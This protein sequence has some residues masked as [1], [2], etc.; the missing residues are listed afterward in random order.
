MG[1]DAMSRQMVSELNWCRGNTCTHSVTD[2]FRVDC[3]SVRAEEKHGWKEFSLHSHDE[4]PGGTDEKKMVQDISLR[5]NWDR[6]VCIL[7][8]IK[9]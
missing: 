6:R 7:E 5:M 2:V 1:S 9:K 8:S 4:S 3:C